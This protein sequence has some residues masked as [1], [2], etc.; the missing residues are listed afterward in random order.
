M[1]L[2]IC[3]TKS[4][5]YIPSERV[6]F[7]SAALQGG[8]GCK[9]CR[10]PERSEGSAFGFGWAILLGVVEPK[11]AVRNTAFFRPKRVGG[12]MKNL[13]SLMAAY[14]AV[15]AIFFVYHYTVAR[16]VARLQD[17]IARLKQ[18]LKQ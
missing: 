7:C 15:W 4:R 18:S 13:D 10:H 1:M 11:K 2:R 3:R 12:K 16:R 9:Q 5:R 17:E 6:A 8:I 14:L